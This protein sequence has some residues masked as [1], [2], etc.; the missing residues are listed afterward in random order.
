MVIFLKQKW[1]CCFAS[2][3]TS[4]IKFNIFRLITRPQKN[5]LTTKKQHVD[6]V[7]VISKENWHANLRTNKKFFHLF[8]EI[9]RN[10][11]TFVKDDNQ[12][13]HLSY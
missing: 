10:L 4:I 11:E 7:A 13:A 2:N 5:I 3:I 6:E 12:I 9:Q 8:P 1:G